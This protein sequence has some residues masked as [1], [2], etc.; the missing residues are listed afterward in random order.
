[1]EVGRARLRDVT[2]DGLDEAVLG[3]GDSP[4]VDRDSLKD[5][6]RKINQL[7]KFGV[8]GALRDQSAPFGVCQRG[9]RSDSRKPCGTP[10]HRQPS[11]E[12]LL[13]HRGVQRG[14][15][16]PVSRGRRGFL[17]QRAA[18]GS[19]GGDGTSREPG[20]ASRPRR[21][22]PSGGCALRKGMYDSDKEG[23]NGLVGKRRRR[24][25][26]DDYSEE[27][28]EDSDRETRGAKRASANAKK[29]ELSEAQKKARNEAWRDH[30]LKALEDSIS[31]RRGGR[32]RV[33][34]RRQGRHASPLGTY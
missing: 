23:A 25:D 21:T 9:H 24:G 8:H 33:R 32:R 19:Q 29:K 7:L 20:P 30:E 27:H 22:L 28:D 1:M 18:R 17:D 26:D 13:H 5:D 10:R 4:T 34:A 11:R 6:T 15:G 14:R 2:K 16:R 3:G 31:A 12:Y